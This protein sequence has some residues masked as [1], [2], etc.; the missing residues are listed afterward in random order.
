MTSAYPIRLPQLISLVRD[1]ATE[2]GETPSENAVMNRFNVGRPKARKAIAALTAPADDST[3]DTAPEPAHDAPD[4]RRLHAVPAL[5]VTV[6]E[7][8][9]A[10]ENAVLPTVLDNSEAVPREETTTTAPTEMPAAPAIGQSSTVADA[11]APK[12]E[13]GRLV[14]WWRTTWRG[15]WPIVLIALGAFVAIWGGWVELGKLTGF[16]EITPLPGIADDWTINSAITLPLGMEAYA[17]Q[18]LQV[19]LS[20]RTRSKKARAFAKWSALG[21]LLLGA[22]G[23]VAYHLMAANGMT[24]APWWITTIV[25]CLP[26]IVLGFGAAL[27][28]LTTRN[29]DET[30]A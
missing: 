3:P 18:A 11:S 8:P 17:A 22:G 13:S 7:T 5:P 4:P 23:Q 26:V 25:S 30:H 27:L 12:A 16:G 6:E 24:V 10:D 14:T 2:L 9:V 19:W 15:R 21:A 20:D 29:D 1:L 28:H